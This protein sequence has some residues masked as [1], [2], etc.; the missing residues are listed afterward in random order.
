MTKSHDREYHVVFHGA[1]W[2]VERDDGHSH[3]ASADRLDA[4]QW[5]IRAAEHDHHDGLDVIVCVE[6][7]DGTYHA[8]WT[9]PR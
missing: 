3:H 4:I 8:A 6:E 5:A 9:S 2:W 1:R 7:P